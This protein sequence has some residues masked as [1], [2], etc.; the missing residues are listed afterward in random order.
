MESVN[1]I[2]TGNSCV[3]PA[4]QERMK[5]LNNQQITNA[6]IIDFYILNSIK[7]AVVE[8]SE[9]NT[10]NTWGTA[11]YSQD[12]IILYRHSVGIFLHELAH[13]ELHRLIGQ[14]VAAHGVV[15]AKML[16]QLIRVWNQTEF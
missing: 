12:R 9:R 8:L 6:Q 2:G 7:P 4:Y 3:S 11:F 13:L 10:K 16:E 5:D 14:C 15:F 1:F